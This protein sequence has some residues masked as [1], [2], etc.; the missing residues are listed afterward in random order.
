MTT[1]SHSRPSPT[2]PVPEWEPA[3]V[4]LP[5]RMLTLV[6]RVACQ[7]GHSRR[8]S[9]TLCSRILCAQ[10]DATDSRAVADAGRQVRA[11]V[12]M[13]L[14]TELG[15]RI[16]RPRLDAALR[17]AVLLDEVTQLPPRQRFALWSTAVDH[18]TTAE[19]AIRTG[20]T[21]PQIAR[22]LRGALRTVTSKATLPG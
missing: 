17:D 16:D 4:D 10:P 19:L 21:S 18:L 6:Y 3:E 15:R 1:E 14:R 8:R 20:W 12:L 9:A 22:L 2:R 13:Q 11:R 7:T 5:G